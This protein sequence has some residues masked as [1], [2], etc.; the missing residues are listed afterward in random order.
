MPDAAPNSV[1]ILGRLD[2]G[3]LRPDGRDFV[4]FPLRH[5]GGMVVEI[6]CFHRLAEICEQFL[7]EDRS[8]LVVGKMV[9]DGDSGQIHVEAG[10]VQFLKEDRP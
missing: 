6:R 4:T 5:S 1:V 9:R 7:K 3:P 10:T 2:E 8:V